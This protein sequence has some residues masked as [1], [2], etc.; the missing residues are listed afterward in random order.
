VR[1]APKS[2]AGDRNVARDAN[3]VA[4]TTIHRR[5][6]SRAVLTTALADRVVERF[7]QP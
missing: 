2:A 1:G 7:T 3:T 5:F 4:R 6:A